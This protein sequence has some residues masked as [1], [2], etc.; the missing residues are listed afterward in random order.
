MGKKVLRQDP[1]TGQYNYSIGETQNERVVFLHAKFSKP[2]SLER[3]LPK[4]YLHKG[5][6]EHARIQKAS[7]AVEYILSRVFEYGNT[8]LGT[9]DS[10]E[11]YRL[12]NRGFVWLFHP[13]IGSYVEVTLIFF[14]HEKNIRIKELFGQLLYDYVETYSPFCFY[15]KEITKNELPTT[16]LVFK[17]SSLLRLIRIIFPIYAPLFWKPL[18]KKQKYQFSKNLINLTRKKGSYSFIIWVLANEIN[19][20]SIKEGFILIE[21]ERVYFV[22]IP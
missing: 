3:A 8:Q 9:L 17:I 5:Q 4:K 15:G 14:L 11:S 13:D 21:N 16:S 2:G 1:I 19:L 20:S 6:L 22:S 7:L 10:G 18:S 12:F